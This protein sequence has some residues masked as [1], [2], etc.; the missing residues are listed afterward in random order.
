LFGWL[1]GLKTLLK[2]ISNDYTFSGVR[3]VALQKGSP[4]TAI[5]QPSRIAAR[6]TTAARAYAGPVVRSDTKSKKNS[7][8]QLKIF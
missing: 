6:A 4:Q 8:N 1:L 2:P 3:M 5:C 7:K